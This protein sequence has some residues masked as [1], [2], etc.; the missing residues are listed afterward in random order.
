M[1]KSQVGQG[2]FNMIERFF[3]RVNEPYG[4]FSNFHSTGFDV[5]EIW[6]PTAEHY[7]QSQ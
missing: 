3:Y 4:A 7:F 2:L 6:R 1:I 5:D